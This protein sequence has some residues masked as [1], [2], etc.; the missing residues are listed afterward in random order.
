[1]PDLDIWFLVCSQNYRRMIKN[2][3]LYPDLTKFPRDNPQIFTSSYGWSTLWLNKKQGVCHTLWPCHLHYKVS[4][5]QTK[6]C[7]NSNISP[8]KNII[9]K[10][11]SSKR[12]QNPSSYYNM[13]LKFQQKPKYLV[14]KILI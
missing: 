10:K 2:L 3:C 9:F 1:L 11:N 13:N 7:G 6:N 8:C 5:R 12:N 14:S 4:L